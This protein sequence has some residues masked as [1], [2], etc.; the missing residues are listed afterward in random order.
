MKKLNYYSSNNL[1]NE[2]EIFDFFIKN[3][4]KTIF[5]WEFYVNWEK[6]KENVED[7][8]DELNLLNWL[9]WKDNSEKKFISLLKRYPR[10]KKAL[11]LLVAIRPNSKKFRK[12]SIISIEDIGK[13]LIKWDVE[14]KRKYFKVKKELDKK[15]I[16]ELLKFYKNSG[17]KNVFEN[18][19][20]KNIKD[21]YFGIEVWMDTHARKNRT[22]DMMEKI[23]YNYLKQDFNN[24]IEQAKKSDIKKRWWIDLELDWIKTNKR[25]DFAIL[26]NS[27]RLFLIEVNYY[28]WW[29]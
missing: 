9:I 20:I 27:W 7:L 10:I 15:T 18:K 19:N 28:S 26:S 22:G 16:D 17:L 11:S 14:I 24:I 8:E 25:F 6:I 13:P 5:T 12:Q 1:E 4:Q 29:H 21:Y 23:V 3:L 2:K